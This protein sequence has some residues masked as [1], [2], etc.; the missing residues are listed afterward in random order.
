[1]RM[2][3][4]VADQGK[5]MLTAGVLQM[6]ACVFQPSRGWAQQVHLGFSAHQCFAV[7][8]MVPVALRDGPRHA[9]QQVSE[10]PHE[11]L[12]VVGP[13]GCAGAPVGR[14]REPGRAGEGDLRGAAAAAAH[15]A[16]AVPLAG[17]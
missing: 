9:G 10:L 6:A 12:E 5:L 14:R 7:G 3:C 15:A 8:P 16:V 13:G 4:R 1:M 11:R 2:P 17:F